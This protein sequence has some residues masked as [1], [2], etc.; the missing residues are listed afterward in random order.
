MKELHKLDDYDESTIKSFIE[1]EIEESINIEFKA[2]EALARTE[3]KKKEISKDVSAFANSDGGIIVYGIHEENNRAHSLSFINGN[4]FSKE[5]LE[6]IISSTI[7]RSIPDLKIYPI[8][9][10]K[11]IE[12]TVYVVKIPSSIEAP[13]ISK[14]KRFYRRYNFE[15]VPMEEYEIRQLYG[16]KVRSKLSLAGYILHSVAPDNDDN[17]MFHCEAHVYNDGE[18]PENEYKVNAYLINAIK[19]MNVSWEKNDINRN[20]DYTI[21]K[22]NKVKVSTV[23]FSP[24]YQ[25]ERIKAIQFNFEIP[26]DSLLSAA[27]QM[28]IN[29]VLFYP[30]GKDEIKIKPDRLKEILLED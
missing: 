28:E 12:R 7:H 23:G 19:G 20:N 16:R 4:E 15:S 14:D 25:D 18:K 3:S 5:W 8:R 30:G 26:W 11:D 27:D 17:K 2:G 21:L 9:F 1:N 24:I 10:D 6:Q 22:S 13:H 29:F